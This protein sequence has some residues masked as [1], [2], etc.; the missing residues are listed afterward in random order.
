MANGN[1]IAECAVL[2]PSS[3]VAAMLDDAIAN[4]IFFCDRIFARINDIKNVL[5]VPSGASKEKNT[6]FSINGQY[7]P[8]INTVLFSCQ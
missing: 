8:I 7:N 6:L 2:P 5:P 4:D 1:I 3:K